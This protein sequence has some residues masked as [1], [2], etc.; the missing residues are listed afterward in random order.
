[1]PELLTCRET[2]KSVAGRWPASNRNGGRIHFGMVADIKS[3][4][5]P[6]S[7]RNTWPTSIGIRIKRQ[8]LAC[9]LKQGA[10]IEG[11]ALSDPEPI[12]SVRTR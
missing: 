12:L 2:P 8:E 4:R 7:R 9:E 11:V 5:W 1:M 6:A 10:E 3:E